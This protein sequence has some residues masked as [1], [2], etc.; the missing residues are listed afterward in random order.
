M[1]TVQGGVGGFIASNARNTSG[2]VQAIQPQGK[3]IPSFAQRTQGSV[4]GMA[5]GNFGS[6]ARGG[7]PADRVANIADMYRKASDITQIGNTFNQQ[8]GQAPQSRTAGS[9]F[10]FG[11][12]TLQGRN[13]AQNGLVN[14]PNARVSELNKDQRDMKTSDQLLD[15]A[16]KVSGLGNV[17]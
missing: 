12:M 2:K 8:G 1:S 3:N 15:E 9:V 4:F 5:A 17:A 10:D 16:I 7:A 13:P 11:K 6:L 14:N